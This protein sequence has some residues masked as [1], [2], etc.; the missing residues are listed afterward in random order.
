MERTTEKLEKKNTTEPDVT[1]YRPYEFVLRDCRQEV[2]AWVALVLRVKCFDAALNSVQLQS[3]PAG[4]NVSRHLLSAE[5]T[6][7]VYCCHSC[8]NSLVLS[9]I[10]MH[11]LQHI[12]MQKDTDL[13]L[14][15]WGLVG[16]ENVSWILIVSWSS[17]YKCSDGEDK[18]REE[19]ES[20]VVM[21]GTLACFLVGNIDACSDFSRAPKWISVAVVSA[22]CSIHHF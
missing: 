21:E 18:K 12:K 5:P 13:F 17:Y 10:W 20:F 4:N 3:L 6:I 9:I 2:A 15:M 1:I 19:D 16:K 14:S 8:F 7:W 22:N 11:H